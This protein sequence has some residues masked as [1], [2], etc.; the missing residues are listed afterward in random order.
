[1]MTGFSPDSVEV[2]ARRLGAMG[3]LRKPFDVDDLRTA[4]MHA[5]GR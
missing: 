5:R 1:M 2:V 4:L 3:V